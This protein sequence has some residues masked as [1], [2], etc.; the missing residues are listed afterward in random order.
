MDTIDADKIDALLAEYA[1]KK[2]HVENRKPYWLFLDTQGEL[3]WGMF[4]YFPE[5]HYKQAVDQAFQEEAE[6]DLLPDGGE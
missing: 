2:D 3:E 6:S 4:N 1:E 5:A